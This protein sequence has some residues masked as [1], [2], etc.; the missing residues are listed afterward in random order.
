MGAWLSSLAGARQRARAGARGRDV[1][2]E[3]ELLLVRR[4]GGR[5]AQPLSRMPC[6]TVFFEVRQPSS[7][8]SSQTRG[9]P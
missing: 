4:D 7:C 8:R 6:A 2:D 9:E 3:C 1:A 5:P